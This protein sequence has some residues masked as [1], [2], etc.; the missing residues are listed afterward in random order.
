MGSFVSCCPDLGLQRERGI[1]NEKW[2]R[3][4][5]CTG[6]A[7]SAMMGSGWWWAEGRHQ[8][9][10]MERIEDEGKEGAGDKVG[11]GSCSNSDRP[12]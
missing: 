5:H 12:D 9:G 1:T 11:I 4:A 2:C 3:H 8:D 7:V 10:K 6:S